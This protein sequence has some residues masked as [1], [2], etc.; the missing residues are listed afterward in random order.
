MKRIA[1]HTGRPY[2][3]IIARGCLPELG[4][5]AFSL[6]PEA[7]RVCVIS[8]SN[9][10]PLY[11]ETVMDS[12]RDAGLKP[13]LFVFPAG[14]ASKN[15]DTIN[16]I[17]A[18][19]AAH[20]LTRADFAVALGGGVTGDMCGFAAATY[21][22]GI[23]FV[24]VPTSLLSQVDSSVGGKT[25]YD[26]PQGKN[27]VGAFWQPSLVLIDP[28]VLRTLPDHCLYDGMAEVIKTAS[29]KDKGLFEALEE[30]NIS[31]EDLICAC[32][33][34]K[35]RVVEQDERDTGARALLNFGH[36]VGHALEKSYGYRGLSHGQGVAI[37]MVAIT[38]AAER[39]GL[40]Q[41]GTADR[42]INLLERSHLPVCDPTPL[43]TIAEA[44]G[45]DKKAVGKDIHLVLLKELGEAFV[46][47][48]P[49]ADFYQFL[50][51]ADAFAEAPAQQAEE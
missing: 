49:Q 27:L 5:R 40:T 3:I 33:D 12:L 24:Q 20:R 44:A 39:A 21:M 37:G 9:V 25:G 34:I 18:D 7:Q 16:R 23:P 31:M 30:Q 43:Q 4:A 2:D 38:K 1:V 41:S 26:L 22:R 35:R 28:D 48:M 14:E 6:L 8:D 15:A 19:F 46:C 47:P 50:N 29:I 32:V 13:S 45:V 10:A 36:T 51:G 17:Y 42:L 11:E